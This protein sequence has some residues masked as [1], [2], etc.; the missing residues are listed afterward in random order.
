MGTPIWL[1]TLTEPLFPL[2]GP[3][4]LPPVPTT[5]LP[6]VDL[7]ADSTLELLLDLTATV[8]ATATAWLLTPT[9]PLS[10]L[11]SPLFRPPVP[12]TLLPS[13]PSTREPRKS[14]LFIPCEF[15]SNSLFP[16]V[17]LQLNTH[18]EPF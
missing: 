6:E 13:E 15:C 16:A 5:S 4:L 14:L 17:F 8:P 9:V 7:L 18:V 2:M 12:T 10:P 1:L 11:M 3:L